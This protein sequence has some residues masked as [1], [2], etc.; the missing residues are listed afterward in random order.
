MNKI[1]IGILVFVGVCVFWLMGSYNGLVGMN[2][3]VN[4]KWAQV[5]NQLQRRYDLIPNLVETVKGYAAHEQQTLEKVIQARNAA[6][7]AQGIPEKAKAENDL[8]QSLK[9]IFAL[10]ENYPDLKAA[11]NF[12]QLQDELVDTEN[13]IQAS[14][15]FYNANV[16]DLNI[17]I[18]V[19]PANIIASMFNFS[20]MSLFEIQNQTER[21]NISVKF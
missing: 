16:R 12:K 19:F 21:E 7:S 8:A 17:K 9:S 4:G 13:K 14:R 3:G 18:D 15:R 11:A 20:K 2:E 1:L 10:S 5:E 6:M